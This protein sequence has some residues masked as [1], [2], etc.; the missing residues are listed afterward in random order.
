MNDPMFGVQGST[1]ERAPGLRGRVIVEE[2]PDEKKVVTLKC[3]N[4][5]IVVPKLDWRTTVGDL[6]AAHAKQLW[7]PLRTAAY[8]N[9][10]RVQD[11]CRPNWGDVVSFVELGSCEV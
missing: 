10:V 2:V 9:G 11:G 3:K 6:R 1:D 5:E 7:L 8:V 4:L